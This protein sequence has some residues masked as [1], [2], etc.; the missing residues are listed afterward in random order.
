M[1]IAVGAAVVEEVASTRATTSSGRSA[2]SNVI[3]V[4]SESWFRGEPVTLDS[5]YPDYGGHP[6]DYWLANAGRKSD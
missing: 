1:G 2:V 3:V 4:E 6:A 5:Q